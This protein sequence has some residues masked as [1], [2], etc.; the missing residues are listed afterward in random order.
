MK[1]ITDGQLIINEEGICEICSKV[2][3]KILMSMGL[4]KSAQIEE[5]YFSFESAKRQE[6]EKQKRISSIKHKRKQYKNAQLEK[7]LKEEK[8]L[9]EENRLLEG[10]NYDENDDCYL[11]EDE[12]IDYLKWYEATK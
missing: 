5:K 11:T 8:E 9:A 3:A 2:G 12:M 10:I 6:T 4:R 1:R 7:V